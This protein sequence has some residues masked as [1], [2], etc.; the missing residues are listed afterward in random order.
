MVKTRIRYDQGVDEDFLSE[1]ELNDFFETVVITGTNGRDDTE[2]INTFDAYFPGRG[3]ITAGSGIIVTT[4]TN[5]V[6][7]ESTGNGSGS[8]ISLEDHELIDSLVHSL[9]ETSTMEILRG[10]PGNKVTGIE[11]RTVP[12]TGTLIRSTEITRVDGKVTQVVDNQHDGGGAII[13]TLTSTINRS[14]GKVTSVDVV[15]T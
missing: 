1:K 11:V 4:G 9:A 6:Q 7:I 8:G 5:F 3:L 13:Q 14:S 2:L 15:E 10:G 12:I